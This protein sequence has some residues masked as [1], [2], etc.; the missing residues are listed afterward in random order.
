MAF[1][2]FV[3]LCI[4]LDIGVLFTNQMMHF[5]FIEKIMS[6]M[7]LRLILPLLLIDGNVGSLIALR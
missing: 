1:Y 7:H 5:N 4:S 6:S 2:Q 3:I